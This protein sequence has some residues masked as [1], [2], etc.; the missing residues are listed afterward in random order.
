M[1]IMTAYVCSQAGLLLQPK[2]LLLCLLLWGEVFLYF[3]L[4]LDKGNVS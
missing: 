2:S 4:K 1:F 3:N